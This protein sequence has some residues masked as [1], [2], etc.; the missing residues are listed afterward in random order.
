MLSALLLGTGLVTI[1]TAALMRHQWRDDMVDLCFGAGNIAIGAGN[2]LIHNW[3][4]AGI[5]CA[6][7]IWCLID[8]WRD[9]R[10]RKRALRAYGAKS[11]ALVAGLVRRAREAARP[12]PVLR[13]A[14]GG[15]R[16]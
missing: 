3:V 15:A 7:G 2:F 11:L 6:V 9:R 1:I 16:A 10:K 13:H 14:P 8:W 4:F 5:S 12:R